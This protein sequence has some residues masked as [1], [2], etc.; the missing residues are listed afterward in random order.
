MKDSS[1]IKKPVQSC[2]QVDIKLMN[3]IRFSLE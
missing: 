1:S 3:E 2:K